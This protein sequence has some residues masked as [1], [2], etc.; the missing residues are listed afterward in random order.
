M[1]HTKKYTSWLNASKIQST[2]FFNS[3]PKCHLE[4]F[5]SFYMAF[6]TLALYRTTIT[7]TA[8]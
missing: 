6:D 4:D 8:M 2:K 7:V 1:L 3:E 5:S